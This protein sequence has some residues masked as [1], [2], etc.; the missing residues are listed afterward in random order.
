M[1]AYNKLADFIKKSN[2]ITVF[3]GAGISCASGIPDF[4]SEN[5]IYNQKYDSL[6]RPEE[7]ISH[8]FFFKHTEDFYDFYCNKMIYPNAKPN[9]AHLFFARLQ[10]I[11]G[12]EVSVVTQN[13]DGLHQKGGSKIVY[14]L[15]GS[16]E[17]N[18]CTS[19]NRFYSLDAILK[20]ESVPK[21][22]VCGEVVK[23]DVV[24][25]EE[26]LD[27][28]VWKKAVKAI[29]DSD[30]MIIV[31]TSLTVYPAASFVRYYNGNKLVLINKQR[32]DYD[33]VADLVINEDVVSVVEQ[34]EKMLF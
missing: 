29:S 16:V 2:K 18:Y 21:C 11:P 33:S 17:R 12:K 5:G 32:T 22:T 15:H 27:E 25:Y 31:G 19:C 10:D 24:L 9:K 3:T 23:P 7:I 30:C 8:T 4:R 6:Y 34:V 20:A 13:I 1:D 26:P 14:E 28:G